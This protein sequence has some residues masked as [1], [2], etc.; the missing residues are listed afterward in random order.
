MEQKPSALISSA[1]LEELLEED[2]SDFRLSPV[3][4]TPIEICEPPTEKDLLESEPSTEA[5]LELQDPEP[6]VAIPIHESQP[7]IY[8]FRY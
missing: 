2:S 8:A 7:G 3:P 5:N 1:L 4:T 6:D